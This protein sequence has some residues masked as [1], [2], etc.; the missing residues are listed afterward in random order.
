MAITKHFF[1]LLGLLVQYGW[2]VISAQI[3]ASGTVLKATDSNSTWNSPNGSFALGFFQ[4]SSGSAAE[5]L[6]SSSYYVGIWHANLLQIQPARVW[7]A[8]RDSPAS[9][10][11]TLELRSDG[12]LVLSDSGSV[13]WDSGTSNLG[14]TEAEVQETGNFVLRSNSS[15]VWETF[16]HPT[17]TIL[18]G[19]TMVYGSNLVAWKAKSDPA[20][21]NYTLS[22]QPWKNGTLRLLF[23]NNTLEYWSQS[24]NTSFQ[25]SSLRLTSD[26]NLGLFDPS[27]VQGW[28]PQSSCLSIPG[29]GKA[30][31]SRLT[32]DPD[33]N[34]RWYN[35]TGTS[36]QWGVVYRFLYDQCSVYNACGENGVCN[37][38]ASQGGESCPQVEPPIPCSCPQ[39]FNPIDTSE[40]YLGCRPVAPLGCSNQSTVLNNTTYD[41]PEGL[42]SDFTNISESSC[43]ALCLEDC[44]C[45]AAIYSAD[46]QAQC[47][48]IQSLLNGSHSVG[49]Q[50]FSRVQKN[51]HVRIAILTTP[52]SNAG[53]KAGIT[54]WAVI[55]I[56]IGSALGIMCAALFVIVL[57]KRRRAYSTSQLRKTLLQLPTE[58]G[59]YGTLVKFS[60][61]YLRAI[62]LDFS[63]KIGSGAFGT[64]YLG[65]APS[66][67]EYEEVKVAVKVL[68][69]QSGEDDRDTDFLLEVES[70]GGT[71]H[72]NLVH[73]L[74]Y[75]AENSKRLLVYEY[76]ENLSLQSKLFYDP[77][78]PW[79]TRF[80][81][82]LGAAK[83]IEY[84][85]N[86]C[87]K[88]IVHRDIKPG[89]I[90]L[91]GHYNAKVSDFGVA[92]IMGL[93][94][95]HATN[96]SLSGTIIY[97]SP[98]SSTLGQPVTVQADVYSF[99]VTLIE[100][101]SGKKMVY[102][103]EQIKKQGRYMLIGEAV[104]LMRLEAYMELCDERLMG[105]VNIEQL[106]RIVKVGIWCMQENAYDRP[107]MED[108]VTTMKGDKEIFPPSVYGLPSYVID[109]SSSS[110]STS[111]STTR[112]RKAYSYSSSSKPISETPTS[113]DEDLPP[114][115]LSE[116][117]R[118]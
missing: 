30:P 20:Q 24:G 98:E 23:V 110:S 55:L 25:I 81:I 79:E 44:S 52:D 103:E 22:M 10:N 5:N 18:P 88:R 68:K 92:K 96:L 53:T 19:Q 49:N 47:W 40:L 95:T 36:G 77:P 11:S 90:L 46:S 31:L 99:G 16:V 35:W 26:G 61:E 114:Q 58:S 66:Q 75:C 115:F 3:I 112:V 89:N 101:V 28:A 6:S 69:D 91:D 109:S 38:D 62:T 87:N 15:T 64:V 107:F 43:V 13:I 74:G 97:K 63:Q 33:G 4:V 86:Y 105:D 32:L 7:V 113:I 34:L 84:F 54:T 42:L 2:W 71:Q 85:H 104:E 94:Q 83:G 118:R 102:R 116:Q 9:S 70:L 17:D 45:K 93:D 106:E 37:V 8:N 14:V 39:G 67:A 41:P 60:Y 29:G 65:V 100:V 111:S 78:L 76:M 1:V 108:V 80:Q 117:H 72:T 51:T 50:F 56:I 73:L 82:V 57:L 12:D 48:L 27:G 59:S 21:G